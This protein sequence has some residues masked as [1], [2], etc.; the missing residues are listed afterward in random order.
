[1]GDAGR[2]GFPAYAQHPLTKREATVMFGD[3]DPLLVTKKSKF[4]AERALGILLLAM[5][6]ATMLLHTAH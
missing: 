3:S 4:P 1:M 2:E 6:I 5:L